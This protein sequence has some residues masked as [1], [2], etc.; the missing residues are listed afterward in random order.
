MRQTIARLEEEAVANA[1]KVAH[2][3]DQASEFLRG[4]EGK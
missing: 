2:T 3:H 4:I 1:P